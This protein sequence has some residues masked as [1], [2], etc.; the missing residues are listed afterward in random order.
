MLS[1]LSMFG[2][3]FCWLNKNNSSETRQVWDFGTLDPVISE[4]SSNGGCSTNKK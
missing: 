1:V 3:S 2:I 4:S